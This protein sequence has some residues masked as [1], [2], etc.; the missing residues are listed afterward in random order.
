[1]KTY[2]EKNPPAIFLGG[3]D[4]VVDDTISFGECKDTAGKKEMKEMK[5]R[6]K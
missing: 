1:M 2:V 3:K 6:T 5:E 4:H